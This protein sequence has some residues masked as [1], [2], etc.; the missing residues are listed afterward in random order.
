M[1]KPGNHNGKAVILHVIDSLDISGGAE[2]QLVA[3]LKSFDHGLL[4]HQVA[5]VKR[6]HTSR[7]QEVGPFT[8]IH[9]LLDDEK[10]TRPR[11]VSRLR[12]LVQEMSPSLIHASLPSSALA[13]RIIA[14]TEGVKAVESLVNIS[15]ER[16]R[17]VD[18]PHVTM[19]KLRLHGAVDRVTMRYL[20]GFHAVSQAVAD[21]WSNTVGLDPA[22]IRV[23]PRGVEVN[24]EGLTDSERM[25]ARK[26]VVDEFGLPESSLIALSV[27]RVEPQKGHRY[28]VE[29]VG[30][31]TR[32]L[33]DLRVLIVGR[34]GHAS[35]AV[36]RAIAAAGLT[37]IVRLTGP[38][39]DLTRLM[40]AADIFVFP[41]LFEGNGGNAMIE[42]MVAGLP[43][44]TTGAPPMTDLVPDDNVG[45]LVDRFDS[46]AL[47]AAIRRLSGDPALR[48]ELGSAARTRAMGFP[49]SRTIAAMHED[50][51]RDLLTG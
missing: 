31:L 33:P 50:W 18:N 37:Q 13:A 35:P 1:S 7:E 21:S 27:G 47:A 36:E 8:P 14:R 25:H 24:P 6:T 38:R 29:A 34:A 11:I 51:Y 28:L 48:K 44:V 30:T 23:M 16:I 4:Q 42:A 41:S 43:I 45:L 12:R 49:S 22:K 2:R 19:T 40:G 3:N 17:T 46:T 39:R 10:A 32:V 5:I 20:T 26:S 9:Y 15:H